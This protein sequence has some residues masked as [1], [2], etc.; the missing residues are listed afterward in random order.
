MDGTKTNYRQ[1]C[2]WLIRGLEAGRFRIE[3]EKDSDERI[4]AIHFTSAATSPRIDP[5]RSAP[6]RYRKTRPL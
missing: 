2:E 6:D 3:T 1:L 5:R 4:L